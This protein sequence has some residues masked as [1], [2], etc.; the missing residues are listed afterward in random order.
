MSIQFRNCAN[1]AA[2]QPI[3]GVA[4]RCNGVAF[5]EAP[6]SVVLRLPLPGYLCP[7]HITEGE[8]AAEGEMEG[9]NLT[10]VKDLQPFHGTR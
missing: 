6:G 7:D 1:G 5:Y 10:P 8:Y 4:Q 3:D 2:W 9:P